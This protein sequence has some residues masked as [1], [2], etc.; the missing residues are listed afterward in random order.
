MASPTSPL[1]SSSPARSRSGEDAR[2][3]WAA[4]LTGDGLKSLVT[5]LHV[6]AGIATIACGVAIAIAPLAPG[7]WRPLAIVGAA[8]RIAGFV[9]FWE[10]Q[11]QLLAKHGASGA[12]ISLILLAGAIAF[13][14]AFG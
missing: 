12:I 5:T 4:A 6:T 10:G 8:T 7:W 11:T 13:P 3:F 2:G 9:V 1:G 14:R